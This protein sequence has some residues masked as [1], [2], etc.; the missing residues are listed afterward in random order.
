MKITVLSETDTE[1]KLQCSHSQ[2]HAPDGTIL[3]LTAKDYLADQPKLKAV[4][5]HC[6]A[7][8]IPYERQPG[9]SLH[10]TADVVDAVKIKL[11]FGDC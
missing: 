3:P 7:E 8:N 4:A 10:V 6:T 9:G 2:K 1:M 5:A 11:L